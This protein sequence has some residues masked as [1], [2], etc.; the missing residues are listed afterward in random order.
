VVDVADSFFTNYTIGK[1]LASGEIAAGT[2]V[3][4]ADDATVYYFDGTNYRPVASE[5]AFYANR[6]SFNDVITISKEITPKAN[7]ITNNEFAYD[8]QNATGP[9]TTASGV[10]VSLSS[11]TPAAASLVASQA[12]A[13]LVSVN[14]TAANDGAVT[15]KSI[16]FKKMGLASDSSVD[17]FY[18]YDGNTRLTDN[19]SMS[20]G[21]VNFS[22]ASLITIPAGQTKTLTV[23]ADMNSDVTTGNIGLSLAAASDV[24][25]TGAIVN[26]SFPINGNIMSLFEAPDDMATV[27][28]TPAAEASASVKAGTTNAVV[29]AANANIGKKA[30]DFKYLALQQIGS[31]YKDDLENFA[32]YVDG[33]K[34]GNGTLNE[35]NELIFDLTSSAYRINTGNHV[36][37]VKADIVKGSNRNFSFQMQTKANIVFTDTNYNVNVAP[38]QHVNGVTHTIS[39]GSTTVA[40]DST[41]NATEIV[42]TASNATLARFTMKAWGEDVKVNQLKVSIDLNGYSSAT[43]T[44]GMNDVAIYVDGNQVGSSQSFT[45]EKRATSTPASD[46]AAR[47][48]TFGSNNLFTIEA[49]EQVTIEVKGSLSLDQ[50]TDITSVITNLVGQGITANAQGVTSYQSIVTH[51]SDITGKTLSIVSGSVTVAKNGAL[52]NMNVSKNSQKVKIGS[53]ILSAGSA[54][55]VVI[56]NIKVGASTTESITATSSVI[57]DNISNLYI[58]ENTDPVQPQAT[59]DFNVNLNLAA[60]ATKIIDVYADLN[61]LDEGDKLQTTLSVTYRTATTNNSGTTTKVDGQVMT[62]MVGELGEPTLVSTPNSFFVLGG[63]ETTAASYKFVADNADAYINELRFDNITDGINQIIVNGVAAAVIPGTSANTG[64]AKVSGLN[65]KIPAGTQGANV[66]IKAVYN[67]V[68]SAGQGGVATGANQNFVLDGYKYTVNGTQ[69]DDNSAN[70]ASKPM[71]LVAS[72]PAVVNALNYTDTTLKIDP[73]AEVMRFKVTATGNSLINLKQIAFKPTYNLAAGTS[74]KVVSIYD[75]ND[76]GTALGTTTIGTS[77]VTKVLPFDEAVTINEGTAKTFVVYADTTAGLTPSVANYFGLSLVNGAGAT[78]TGWAWNDGTIT[79]YNIDGTH[80][81]EFSGTTFT[82]NN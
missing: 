21:Y 50:D 24:V 59:N 69:S 80:I 75:E 68:T 58:S 11:A 17:S 76:L 22:G 49:G 51:T 18:L 37:E 34:A 82:L 70:I 57:M 60:N 14:L 23:K 10:T 62:V 4:N 6:F 65:I 12:L 78:S 2:L 79:G 16:K 38:D 53:Y 55:G 35:S 30:V 31:I 48:L 1:P 43:T 71:K 54:E 81:A 13:P 20:N 32:I 64:T 9:V 77:G 26:G 25:S 40:A 66:E 39:S 56:S 5:S 52:Q 36:I 29:W 72:Y 67:N 8:A 74:D 3:K 33:I 15:L 63:S 7:A 44:E 42:R 73:K 46:P 41:F 19:S 27:T 45:I 61:E 47:N 28:L